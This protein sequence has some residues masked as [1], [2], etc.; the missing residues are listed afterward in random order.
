MP[1]GRGLGRPRSTCGASNNA[2]GIGGGDGGRRGAA[3]H[4]PDAGFPASTIPRCGK[5]V[6]GD[7]WGRAA[8]LHFYPTALKGRVFPGG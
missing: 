7:L 8:Y 2:D 5:A 1:D 4:G 3:T 6:R